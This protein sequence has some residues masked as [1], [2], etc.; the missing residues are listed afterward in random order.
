MILLPD[1]V[2]FHEDIRLLIY[3]PRGL[4]AK[5]TINK[6]V[7]II[8]DL[9]AKLQEPFNRFFDTLG[10]DEVE[11]NF[12]YVIQISLHRVLSYGDRP[13]VK[14]AILAT[15]TTITHYCQLHA[16]ITKDSPI[17]VRIF[18]K[19]EDAAKWLGVPLARL[20]ESPREPRHQTEAGDVQL[21]TDET[22][23]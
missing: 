8:G 7:F 18:Q 12:R 13:P 16:I 3:R 19:R 17:N 10:H 21:M 6:I 22:S 5:T 1:D 4:L 15:D 20:G 9:E 23:T 11:L 2:E 14:S